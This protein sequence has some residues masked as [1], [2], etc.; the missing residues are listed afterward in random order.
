MLESRGWRVT[1]SSDWLQPPP[2]LNR[3]SRSV[4][5]MPRAICIVPGSSPWGSTQTPFPRNNV[6]SPLLPIDGLSRLSLV[7]RL[8]RHYL[9]SWHYL[10]YQIKTKPC[11]PAEEKPKSSA[12][13][14]K[15]ATAIPGRL[16]HACVPH[17]PPR[18]PEGGFCVNGTS[19]S[20]WTKKPP[21]AVP[22]P[23]RS[24]SSNT[25][26]GG[27]NFLFSGPNLRVLN[28]A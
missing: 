2:N 18:S 8:S 16:D 1:C 28:R 27:K 17:F 22:G 20:P 6:Y 5:T 4:H 7:I 19:V 24:G 9:A 23:G 14:R 3:L 11:L 10:A 26:S 15:T 21:A 13:T 25:L 12:T